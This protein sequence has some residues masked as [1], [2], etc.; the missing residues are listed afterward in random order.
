MNLHIRWYYRMSELCQVVYTLDS[1]IVKEL[2]CIAMFLSCNCGLDAF[3]SVKEDLL[4]FNFPPT[5]SITSK[6]LRKTYVYRWIISI[7]EMHELEIL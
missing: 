5:T 3:P 6:F 7:D 2:E 1:S 4:D